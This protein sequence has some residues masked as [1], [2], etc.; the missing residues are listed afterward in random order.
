MAKQTGYHK[1]LWVYADWME[2]GDAAF[3]G[4]LTAEQLRGKEAFSFS[5]S[6]EWLERGA[7]LILD[8]DLGLFHGPH[9][10]CDGKPNFGLFLDSSPDRWGR[11]LMERREALLARREG[12]RPRAL[13][14]SDYLLGVFDRYRMGGLRFKSE[15]AGPFLNHHERAAAPP[16][17][18]LRTLEEASLQLEDE[19]VTDNPQFAHWLNLLLSPGSSLGGARPRASVIDSGGQL[20]IAKFPS[21]K[22][23]RSVSRWRPVSGKLGI[24]RGEA[25]RMERCFFKA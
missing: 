25:E 24:S 17:T 20:W 8:P 13:T 2:P 19:A 14:E 5:Y 7:A 15:A 9:Y 11:E 12:R 21:R 23:D 22:D 16:M 18:S 3:M 6:K 10:I 4:M 1:Q